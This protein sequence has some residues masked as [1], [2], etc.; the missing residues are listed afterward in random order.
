LIVYNIY[1]LDFNF[2]TNICFVFIILETVKSVTTTWFFEARSAF[3]ALDVA[4]FVTHRV[5]WVL[6]PVFRRR[7]AAPS[8][9]AQ[10]VNH[11]L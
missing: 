6:L 9:R 8:G 3:Q 1:Y 7:L 5:R 10:D 4:T 11:L 2:V